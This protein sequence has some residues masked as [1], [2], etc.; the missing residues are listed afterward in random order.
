[1]SISIYVEEDDI[2]TS[3][4]LDRASLCYLKGFH[5]PCNATPTKCGKSVEI[6]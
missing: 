1:M 4:H 5:S 6:G 2:Q 3:A